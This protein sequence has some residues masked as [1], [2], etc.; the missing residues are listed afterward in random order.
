MHE[1]YKSLN[2]ILFAV[3]EAKRIAD[4]Q[5]CNHDI[6]FLLQ[7]IAENAIWGITHTPPHNEE[8]K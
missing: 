7:E 8:N 4:E 3:G 2:N 5:G 6:N 1:A